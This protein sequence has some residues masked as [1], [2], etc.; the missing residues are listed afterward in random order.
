[1]HTITDL[2]DKFIDIE[3][4]A[5][6]FY[7]DISLNE[8]YD[9]QIRLTSKIFYLEE[10]RHAKI[11]EEL[12]NYLL[13]EDIIEIDFSVYDRS[14]KILN[15]FNTNSYKKKI[16]NSQD[17]VKVASDMEKENLALALSVQGIMLENKVNDLAYKKLSKIIKDEEN[18]VRNISSFI[19]K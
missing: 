8:E 5:A 17:L 14:Y 1:M 7:K 12:K 4:K 18:H 13:E 3:K 19:S 15:S 9:R 6:A 2:I 16:L 10:L 11:Y